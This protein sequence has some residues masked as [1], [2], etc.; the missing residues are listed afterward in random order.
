MVLLPRRLRLPLFIFCW[1]Q[2][3][4]GLSAEL[5]PSVSTLFKLIEQRLS[6]MDDVAQY[7]WHKN[8][9]IEDRQREAEVLDKSAAAAA[10]FNLENVSSRNFF[11]LQIEAAKEIQT[12]WFEQWHHSTEPIRGV[13]LVTIVRPKLIVLGD[14]I[15]RQ[16]ELSFEALQRTDPVYLKTA[17]L[18]IVDVEHLSQT[19]SLGLLST[20]KTIRLEAPRSRLR[21]IIASGNIYVGTTGDYAPFSWLN[22]DTGSYSGIDIDLARD[23]A[24]S[25]QVKLVLVPTSWPALAQDFKG[26][27]FD[28][29]MSGVSINLKRQQLGFFSQA[30]HRGGKTP[31]ARCSDSL[32]YDSLEKINQPTTRAIV[33]PGG[34]NFKF[35]EKNLTKTTLRIFDDNQTIFEEIAENRAD[36][37]ITDAIEVMLQ[38]RQSALLCPTMPGQTLTVSE[39]GFW[40]QPDFHFKEY[41][42]Q[43]LHQRKIE[44][45][46][47]ERIEHHLNIT[48]ETPLTTHH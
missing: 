30:Y 35:A 44:G 5:D 1:I 19:T 40:I 24:K 13:D 26:Q 6:Y 4:I 27:K 36:V 28:I 22:K 14:Q 20:L 41:V 9:A 25:L 32:S 34:T 12:G 38:S 45:V 47:K 17:F 2:S 15:L 3:G 42:D 33:N 29:A 48:A 16:I 39:K 18:Q 10:R 7:K 46:V 8:L 11:S 31:I 21:D 37:M 23:L 43:W